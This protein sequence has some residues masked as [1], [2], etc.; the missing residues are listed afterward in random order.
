[1]KKRLLF[2]AILG[3]KSFLLFSAPVGNP[4]TPSLLEEGFWIP[5]TFWTNIQAGFTADY[6]FQKKLKASPESSNSGIRK[7]AIQGGSQIGEIV[8]SV[9]ERF[10]LGV[11]LGTGQL[12]WNWKQNGVFV[13][14]ESNSGFLWSG[15]AQ[16]VVFEIKD[17][18]FSALGQVGG[19][20][21]IQAHV[22]LDGT[23]LGSLAQIKLQYWQAG[24]AITQKIG[25]FSP[26]LGCLA[27]Q[28]VFRVSRLQPVSARLE[29]ATVVGPFLGCTLSRGSKFFLNIEWRGWFEEG[30]SLSGQLR[31]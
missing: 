4:A 15:E 10:N 17:T 31:F 2:Q 27:N 5:D 28:S 9:R 13:Q 25:L 12:N 23:Q 7:A 14:G 26:Y 24:A 20:N 6:L 18:A 8:W 11:Q 29:S 1:M 30:V 22:S 16:L 21:R 3:F 19:I